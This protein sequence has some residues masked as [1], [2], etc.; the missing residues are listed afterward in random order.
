M[1]ITIE[2]SD[3]L[4]KRESKGQILVQIYTQLPPRR[5]YLKHFDD[6]KDNLY[7]P[8]K[9][10]RNV[11]VVTFGASPLSFPFLSQLIRCFKICPFS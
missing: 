5:Q 7:F 8:K 6:L 3:G 10:E 11:E 1:K 2:I 9:N 4:T